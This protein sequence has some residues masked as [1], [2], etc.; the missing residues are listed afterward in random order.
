MDWGH[1]FLTPLS[2]Q[3]RCW[4]RGHQWKY[5]GI[6]WRHQR[7]ERKIEHVPGVVCERCGWARWVDELKQKD[8]PL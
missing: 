1:F 2:V 7:D 4:L 3:A 8:R 5:T 6:H